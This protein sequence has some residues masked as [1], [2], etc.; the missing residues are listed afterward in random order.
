MPKE[1]E[2]VAVPKAMLVE[3]LDEAWSAF[4]IVGQEF[5]WMDE[6]VSLKAKCEELAKYAGAEHIFPWLD[7]G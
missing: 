7:E 4:G 5:D 6:S 3:V 2:M 1:V